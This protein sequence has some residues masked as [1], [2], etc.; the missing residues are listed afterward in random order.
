MSVPEISVII[1]S[2]RAREYVDACMASM[3]HSPSSAPFEVI[4]VES[5][6]DGTAEYIRR[7]HPA[8]NVIALPQRAYPGEARNIGIQAAQGGII[9]FTDMDCV[10]QPGWLD[11]IRRLHRETRYRVIGGAVANG[12]PD[13]LIGTAEYFVEFNEF[14][15]FRPEGEAR[16]L[17]T[18]NVALKKEIF[19]QYGGFEAVI[20]GSDT[21]FTRRLIEQGEPIY[22]TPAFQVAHRNRTEFRRFLNNQAELGKGSAQ[23]R[24]RTAMPGSVMV[25][26]PLLIPL[27]PALRLFNIGM[28]LLRQRPALF[29]RFALLFPWVGAGLCSYARGFWHEARRP[30][31]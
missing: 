3:L 19:A 10:A 29:M 25:R 14:T 4:I 20:K 31:S 12:T 27:I 28:R 16:L 5:S 26:Q 9:V 21:L 17:P 24:R 8:V 7:A 13:S 6:G 11:T 2:Y 22:F 1:P 18:C 30:S 23:I 15:P